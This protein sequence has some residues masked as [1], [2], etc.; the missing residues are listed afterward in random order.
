MLPASL[1]C[2]AASIVLPVCIASAQNIPDDEGPVSRSLVIRA[3]G[4]GVLL[5]VG[6]NGALQL[7]LLASGS[8]SAASGGL[9][10]PPRSSVEVGLEGSYQQFA[11]SENRL[12]TYRFARLGYSQRRLKPVPSSDPLHIGIAAVGIGALAQV[13]ARLGV[14]ADVGPSWTVTRQRQ[15]FTSFPGSSFESVST[16]TTWG[17][18]TRVGV[19]LRAKPSAEPSPSPSP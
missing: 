16:V 3:P 14:M 15:E 12:R 1:R 4:V 6:T 7:T 2:L 19:T 11:A 13:T 5:P 17:L 9:D 18:V 8:V 10:V